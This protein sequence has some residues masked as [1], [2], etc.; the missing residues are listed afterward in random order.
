MKEILT[1]RTRYRADRKG[2][3]ILQIE[4]NYWMA[5]NAGASVDIDKYI[6]WRD[7]KVEDISIG[8]RKEV[9]CS[10]IMKTNL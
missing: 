5:S 9:K 6:G 10:Y 1:G 2:R 4:R 8:K 7:A 3:L